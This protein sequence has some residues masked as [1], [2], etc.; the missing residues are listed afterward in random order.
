MGV[1]C[2]ETCMEVKRWDS[3]I[4][5]GCEI[6]ELR[7]MKGKAGYRLMGNLVG[8]KFGCTGA[9]QMLAIDLGLIR[10]GGRLVWKIVSLL[11]ISN[12]VS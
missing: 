12:Y 3:G 7:M 5:R 6:K 4:W 9:G 8:G 1:C 11:H 10:V 2:E